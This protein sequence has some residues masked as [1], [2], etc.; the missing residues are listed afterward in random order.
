VTSA[1]LKAPGT[2][3]FTLH[4]SRT[5]EIETMIN[6]ETDEWVQSLATDGMIWESFLI[7]CQK[8]IFG[9]IIVFLLYERLF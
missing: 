9:F 7:F 3:L 4:G 5:C 2:I 6:G 8:H 1:T